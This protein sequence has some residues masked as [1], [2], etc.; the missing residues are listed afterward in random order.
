MSFKELFLTLSLLAL[1]FS[2][3][4]PTSANIIIRM[5]TK[6]WKFLGAQSYFVKILCFAAILRVS[7]DFVNNLEKGD[8]HGTFFL[9]S[10]FPVLINQERCPTH[11]G[12]I[13]QKCSLSDT[14]DFI[15]MLITGIRQ[16]FLPHNHITPTLIVSP[17]P[18]L[19]PFSSNA[20]HPPHIVTP[21]PPYSSFP[22]VH[23][24]NNI[25]HLCKR[26]LKSQTL[27][28]IILNYK[29]LPDCKLGNTFLC[30]GTIF[31]SLKFPVANR[32]NNNNSNGKQSFSFVWL[33]QLLTMHCPPH[34]R[35]T[36][37]RTM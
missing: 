5:W 4:M 2:L 27:S 17:P 32:N 33:P 22:A 30:L 31:N 18:F 13:L 1:P 3:T 24:V 21:L 26:Y 9:P 20:L 7:V 35:Y 6:T 11:P 36:E 23:T 19:S 34:S 16:Q 29:H 14:Y 25:S 37:I 28:R 15:E 10:E 8:L 12:K